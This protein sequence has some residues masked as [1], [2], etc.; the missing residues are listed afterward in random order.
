MGAWLQN[1][2]PVALVIFCFQERHASQ[3]SWVRCPPHHDPRFCLYY[4]WFWC[5]LLPK[6]KW[7][8]CIHADVLAR[9]HLMT[10]SSLWAH[11]NSPLR[12]WARG[13]RRQQLWRPHRP[14][15]PPHFFLTISTLRGCRLCPGKMGECSDGSDGDNDGFLGKRHATSWLTQT[16]HFCATRRGATVLLSAAPRPSGNNGPSCGVSRSRFRCSSLCGWR[17]RG[18]QGPRHRAGRGQLVA[19]F[20]VQEQVSENGWSFHFICL[21]IYLLILFI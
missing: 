20:A 15:F 6:H 2:L 19:P 4:E 17:L 1:A 5:C 10:P 12:W 7:V 16:F 13:W 8:W 9:P 21:F 18:S 11:Q 3:N 14:L